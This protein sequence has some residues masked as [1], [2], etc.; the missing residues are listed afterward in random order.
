MTARRACWCAPATGP[1]AREACR[2]R[3]A[4]RARA[5]ARPS[6]RPGVARRRRRAAGRPG[7]RD[8]A[9]RRR[10]GR[11]AVRGVAGRR[12]LRAAQPPATDDE[13]DHIL[14]SVGPAAVVTTA[15]RRRP[16]RRLPRG[17][18]GRA[19]DARRRYAPGP[20]GPARRPVRATSRS[21]SS[22]RGRRGGPKPVLLTHAGVTRPARR[23]RSASCGGARRA[24]AGAVGAAGRRCPTWCRCRCRCGPA[25]TTCCSPCGSAPRWW[26][27]DGFD[28]AAF[29]APGP[30][31]RHPLDRAAA[32]G[33]GDAHRRAG[34]RGRRPGPA[35]LRPQHHRAAVAAAGPAV[36]RPVR[37]SPCS[38]ATARPRS[39]AR[40]SAG[41]R[42]TPASTATTS[43][44][45]IGRPHDG[46]TA[47]VVDDDG[48]DVAAGEPASCGC[49]RPRWPPATRAAPT[50]P[51][52]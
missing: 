22:R 2:R 46:V 50:W 34:R 15:E 39:A 52:G 23:R 12:R 21:S 13:V 51:T 9:Q 17:G 32:G 30:P 47:R 11:R 25:S 43:S 19:G 24:P 28:T 35:A 36:P 33:D 10:R 26:C 38:T 40:S 44:G 7:R 8:A 20:F 27:M 6:R 18:P 29:A 48:R 16:L 42:P 49:A 3:R 4:R 41:T 1:D 45:S 37:R 31:P 14:A 5:A